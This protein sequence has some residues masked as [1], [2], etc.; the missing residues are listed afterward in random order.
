MQKNKQEMFE[1]ST[2]KA[3]TI[4]NFQQINGKFNLFQMK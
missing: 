1:S 3:I 4:V 2:M